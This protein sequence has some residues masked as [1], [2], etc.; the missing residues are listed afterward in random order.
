MGKKEILELLN[1]KITDLEIARNVARCS[2]N[3][4]L[5]IDAKIEVLQEMVRRI[6]EN[7]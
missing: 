2:D 6:E 5:I 4:Y 3:Y 1:D 7:L